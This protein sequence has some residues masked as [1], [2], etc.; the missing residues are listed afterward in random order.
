M[1][2]EDLKVILDSQFSA[3]RAIIDANSYVHESQ[4]KE[5]V[6]QNKVRNGR[7]D[8][9]EDHAKNCVK[10]REFMNGIGKNW[11]LISVG[12]VISLL[13]LHSLFDTVNIK[14]IIY[15]IANKII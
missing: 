10:H 4:L 3:V 12:I 2:N 1:K 13:L 15:W 9:L 14:T 5:I 6:E 8:E 7:I 11:K